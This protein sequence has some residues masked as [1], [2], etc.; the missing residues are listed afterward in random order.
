MD[1]FQKKYIEE[2]NELIISLE[3][4]LLSL[5][6]EQQNIDIIEEVFRIMHSLKGGSSMFGFNRISDLTHNLESAYDIIRTDKLPVSDELLDVSLKA[7]DQLKLL[8][9]QNNELDNESLQKQEHLLEQINNVLENLELLSETSPDNSITQKTDNSTNTYF[10]SFFPNDDIFSNGTN[11]L[12]IIDELT[13]IGQTKVT[14]VIDNIPEI[15]ELNSELCYTGWNIVISTPESEESISNVF[16]FV[17]DDADIKITHLAKKDLLK[18]NKFAKLIEST[19]WEAKDILSFSKKTQEVIP[20]K[21]TESGKQLKTRINDLSISSVRVD[22]EKLDNLLNIVSEIVTNQARLNLQVEEKV[23]DS[24]LINIAEDFNKLSRQLR[25]TAFEISLVPLESIIVRFKRLVRDLANEQNKEIDFITEGVETELDKTI[26]EHLVSPIMHTIRNSI[27]HGI[28]SKEERKA[29]GKPEIGKITLKAYHSGPNVIVQI[30]DDGKG[31]N[32]KLIYEKALSK[33]FIKPEEQFTD[34]EIIN[35]IFK[36]G[37][38]TASQVTDISGRGVGMDVVKRK[39][40]EVRGEVEID[41]VLNEGTIISIKLPLTLSIIDGLL[42]EINETKFILPLPEVRKIFEIEHSKVINNFKELIVF[43]G[44]QMPYV[45]LRKE[46][47]ITQK[48]PELERVI[49]VNFEGHN[50]GI[51]VDNVL[52][53]YQAVLKPLGYFFRNQEFI[54]GASIFGDGTVS[55]VLDTNKIIKLFAQKLTKV[56]V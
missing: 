46:F 47:E 43:Q 1:K 4:S 55:L 48:A 23:S 7:I 33:G 34:K 45:Y 54:S 9:V 2:A 56:T 49:V 44:E 28:E 13:E 25:D 50:V 26:I 29:K 35:L 41:S 38:T 27:D 22:S 10:I 39:I 15:E 30:S 5:E 14:P 12:Y 51:I 53:E 24:T 52:G 20:V 21:S 36:A 16:L 42:I 6:K 8:L 11:P 18:N 37:F 31:I 3:T 19:D 17:E 32:P 40:D